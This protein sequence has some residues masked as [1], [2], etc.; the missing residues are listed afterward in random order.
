VSVVVSLLFALAAAVSKWVIWASFMRA[1]PTLSNL[2]QDLREAS[3][4][5]FIAIHTL[6]QPERAMPFSAHAV[7]KSTNLVLRHGPI[8]IATFP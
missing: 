6:A 5:R 4:P 8:R 2:R 1:M 3:T 7:G